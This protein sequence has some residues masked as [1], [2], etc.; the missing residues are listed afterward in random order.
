M[1][2]NK[3]IKGKKLLIV[4][5]LTPLSDLVELAHRNGVFVGVADY[6]EDTFLKRI[7]DAHHEVSATDVD[8]IVQLCKEEHYDGII[9]N[10]NDMLIPFVAK[11]AEALGTWSPFNE[12][13]AKMST[14]KHYFKEKCMEFGIAVPKEYDIKSL[15]DVESDFVEYPIIIKPADNGGS[16][17]I[18]VCYNK[19]ELIKGYEKAVD[20]SR[21]G[22]VIAEQFLPY[23]EINLTYIIQDGVVQLAAI[24][25]RYFNEQQQGVIKVPD[26][27]IYPS[28]YTDMFIERYNARIISMLQGIGLKNGSLFIQA[29]VKGD[30]VY[31]YEA[32]MR[33][34]GCK[35]YQILEVENDYNTFE[36]LMYY[37]LTGS[38]GEYKLFNP[39]FKR[40][41]ATWC[42]V[43]QPGTVIGK[44]LGEKEIASY[45]W[46]IHNGKRYHEGDKIPENSAGTLGQLSSRIHIYADTKEQLI[47]RLQKV[48]ELYRPVDKEGESILLPTHDIEDIKESLNYELNE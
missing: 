32:G 31:L 14:D 2:D 44:Y 42:V 21:S 30:E 45:P 46:F 20:A 29:V 41:Y 4:G 36:H 12:E 48:F 15:D 40:W 23:D 22:R 10:F 34:N 11:E 33:L 16:R 19:Q 47:E 37:A 9:S 7:A 17:G 1:L 28:R 24:H 39:K 38:M 8:A 5:G 27:Y 43:S 6:N 35:T 26:L 3:A 18:S 25:D 13:Q